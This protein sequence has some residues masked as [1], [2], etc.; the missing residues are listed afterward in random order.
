MKRIFL[1][2]FIVFLLAGCAKEASNEFVAY[3]NNPQN[4]TS[5]KASISNDAPVNALLSL[6]SSPPVVDSFDISTGGVLHCAENAVIIFP[7]NCTK[8]TVSG[9]I[10]V[11]AIFLKSKGDMVRFGKPTVSDNYVLVSGGAFHIK[12]VKDGQEL[13]VSD[14]VRISV[15]Y[16][17]Q[18]LDKKMKVFYGDTSVNA[19]DGFNWVPATDSSRIDLWQDGALSGYNIF[20]KNIG[21]INCDKFADSTVPSTK[22]NAVLPV[23][24]TNINTAVFIVFKDQWSVLRMSADVPNRYFYTHKVPLDKKVII[25]SISLIGTD[26][27]IGAKDTVV[28]ADAV[29]ELQPVVKSKKDIID[30]LAAL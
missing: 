5:W 30:F 29:I 8:E 18:E 19:T 9:K 17:S 26:L 23:N 2:S 20:P 22:L 12:I 28:T 3:P 24:F 10:I 25:V 16:V 1:Y 15:K 7:A 11:E 13:H 6:L 4:D 21:W 14:A 27:Y